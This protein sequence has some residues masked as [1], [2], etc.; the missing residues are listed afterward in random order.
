MSE[1]VSLRSDGHSPIKPGA[2]LSER[3]CPVNVE[4]VSESL[5]AVCDETV[6][7]L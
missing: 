6:P 5:R 2:E 1:L 3:R 7:V 4:M